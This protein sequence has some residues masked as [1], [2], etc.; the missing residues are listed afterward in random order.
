MNAK[1]TG[2]HLV[3]ICYME[4]KSKHDEIRNLVNKPEYICNK[5]CRIANIASNLCIPLA[6]DEVLPGLN[7]E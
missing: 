3:H 5:C 1:C 4:T 7:L 2:N 6:L